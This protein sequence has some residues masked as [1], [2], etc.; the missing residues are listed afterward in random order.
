MSAGAYRERLYE[1]FAEEESTEA[2]IDH[3]LEIGAKYLDL[4]IGFFTHIADGVQEIRQ[5][6]GDHDIIQPGETCP[7]ESA[8]CER[9]I[10]RENPLAVQ[11]AAASSVINRQAVETFGLGAYIGAHVFVDGHAYGTVCFAG[12]TARE[13]QFTEAEEVFIE[14]VA[15]LVGSAI[16]RQQHEQEL[17][18]RNDALRR[19][20]RRFQA[21]AETS[22][23]IIF[24]V[25]QE[26][27]FTYVSSAVERILGYTPS[28]I[29]GQPFAAF[30]PPAATERAIQAY[31]SVLDGDEIRNVELTFCHEDG[32][33]VTIEVNA[34][35]VESG[36]TVT[37]I[38]GV[39]RDITQRKDRERELRLKNRA[40]DEA[41]VGISIADVSDPDAPLVYAN[42]GFERV[43]GYPADEAIGRNCRFLQG[44]ATDTEAV[45]VLRDAIET[46]NPAATALVNY[47]SDGTPFRNE[48]RL[49]PVENE[50]GDVSHFVGFQADITER[51]RT[52]RLIRVLNRVLRHN[53][54]NDANAILGWASVLQ[55]GTT[56]PEEAGERIVDVATDIAE[57]T[58]RAR[59]LER[60]ASRDRDPVRIDPD[61]VVQTAHT[62]RVEN[63]PN[64]TLDT[65]VKTDRDLVAGIEF[66]CAALELVDNAI[67]HHPAGDPVIQLDVRDAGD[68]LEFSVTDDGWGIEEDEASVI[69][70]GQETALRHGSGLGLWL[71]NWIVTRYAGTFDIQP[72]TNTPGTAARIRLP[73]I[74]PGEEVA[75][76]ARPPTVL[77]A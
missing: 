67:K 57:L 72:R 38:H 2:R 5:S 63:W 65:T 76:V 6:V 54:R 22:S 4:P 15:K 16:E 56:A 41:N 27:Q 73:A 32:Q 8:Y 9:T 28:E 58:E 44:Q 43:T 53:V 10:D 21:I 36:G 51:T 33:H 77:F 48:V 13:D 46:G 25:D 70:S 1:T 61:D 40:M 52:T 11:D 55:D 19:E 39:G 18:D 47:R 74:E 14:L 75:S 7:L 3:A 31:E 49:A 71:V 69:D 50:S 23:D 42:D 17:R 35:P 24:R 20:K 64:A 62:H 45:S 66:E 37:G 29:E 68:W 26:G 34:T 59:D 30:M 12:E 60:F